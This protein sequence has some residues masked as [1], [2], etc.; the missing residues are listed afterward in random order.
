MKKVIF[1]VLFLFNSSCASATDINI[2]GSNV[3]LDSSCTL[4][5][6]N[7]GNRISYKPK[8]S[9]FESC[10][11]VSHSGTNIVDV[12]YINGMYILFIESNNRGSKG[13]SSEYTSVGLSKNMRL[14][15]TDLVKSSASCDQGQEVQSFEYFAKKLKPYSSIK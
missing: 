6:E 9:H 14:H 2:F 4:S 8:F 11:L 7:M 5:I 12:K 10:R 15:T 1:I 3:A 13:C